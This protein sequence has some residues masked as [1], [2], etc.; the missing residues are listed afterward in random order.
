MVQYGLPPL[1]GPELTSACI[2]FG[3]AVQ[4]CDSSLGVIFNG[5]SSA[6][7]LWY[8]ACEI[9][10]EGNHERLRQ[11][12]KEKKQTWF[13][14]Q[15]ATE[16]V[17]SPEE[18]FSSLL[19]VF[20]TILE[21]WDVQTVE[22]ALRGF[23]F[24]DERLKLAWYLWQ[25]RH[26]ILE[27]KNSIFEWTKHVNIKLEHLSRDANADLEESFDLQSKQTVLISF[28][29]RLNQVKDLTKEEA[30]PLLADRTISI[31]P[32]ISPFYARARSVLSSSLF[33]AIR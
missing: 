6:A 17:S 24:S 1:D 22:K 32:P 15:Q 16:P 29:H 4:R 27:T 8:R 13:K 23:P 12:E 21:S 20:N 26:Y 5:A 9:A 2:E 18:H 31:F 28:W 11:L 14:R 7:F 30:I 25:P 3:K 19:H 33:P 10:A